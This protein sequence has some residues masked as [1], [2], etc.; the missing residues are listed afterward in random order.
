MTISFDIPKDIEQELAESVPDLNAEAREAF[1]VSLYREDRITH[2][3][4]GQA[5]GLSRLET[6]AVLKRHKVSSGVTSEELEAQAA[7]FR[8]GFANTR[9]R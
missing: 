3:Q 8:E 7:A 5:L 1:L 4:L 9:P 2:H 6:E